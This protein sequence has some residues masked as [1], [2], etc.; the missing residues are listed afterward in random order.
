M[1]FTTADGVTLHYRIDGD[2]GLPLLV[3]SNGLGT[4]LSMW[5]AQIPALARAFR[6]MRYDARGH[7]AS[8]TPSQPFSIEHLGRDVLALL[9]CA[10]VARAH[11]CGLSMGGMIGMWLGINA[12]DRLNSLV[13]ANTAALIGPPAMW[14]ERIDVVSAKGMKAISAAAVARWFTADF[15]TR[16]PGAVAEVKAAMER[17][18]AD[19]YVACC[20]AIRDAD[21]RD[22]IASI[23]TPVLVISG[24]HDVATPPADALYLAQ[25]I[26]GSRSLTLDTAHL[27]N[28]ESSREFSEALRSF[29]RAND[30]AIP[31]PPEATRG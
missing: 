4:E 1:S 22:A 25:R 19:G 20:A 6:V 23:R 2:D 21:F 10:G 9:D 11:F 29:C 17:T 3:L 13:L 7:G 8:S 24:A 18:S 26:A 12:P 30:A 27:S 31:T 5:D 14:N 15:I 16:Q 28:I